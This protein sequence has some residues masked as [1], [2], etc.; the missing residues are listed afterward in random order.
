MGN[1][2]TLEFIIPV[3]KMTFK[4]TEEEEIEIIFPDLIY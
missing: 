4:V 3:E 2:R 1:Y